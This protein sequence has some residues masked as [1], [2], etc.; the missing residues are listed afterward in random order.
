MAFAQ[1]FNV[2]TEFRFEIGSAVLGTKTLQNQVE[3][4]SGAVDGAIVNFQRL[5]MA[6]IVN[7]GTG[8]GGMIGLLMQG[9][10]A[11]EHYRKAQLNFTNAMTALGPRLTG[12]IE[13]FNKK[14][15]AS[16]AL[17]KTLA[18][19]AREFALPE[20]ELVGVAEALMPALGA[21]GLLGKNFD[22]L[23]EFSR[24]MLKAAPSM[25]LEAG[26]AMQQSLM[27]MTGGAR[28]QQT[29]FQR[30]TF[31]TEA[32]QQF[33]NDA[34]KFNKLDPHKKFELIL[35]SLKQFTKDARVL[36]ERTR[37]VSS[38]FM[39]IRNVL[40]G[41]NGILLPFGRMINDTFVVVLQKAEKLLHKYGREIVNN[42]TAFV[43]PMAQSIRDLIV[44]ALQLRDVAADVKK[45]GITLGIFG[46]LKIFGGI[47]I[48]ITLFKKFSGVFTKLFGPAIAFINKLGIFKFLL[49]SLRF[50]FTKL[51]WPIT[52]LIAAFQLISRAK[53]I[54]NLRDAKEL[55]RQMAQF[56]EQTLRL[57]KALAAVTMPFRYFF[58][59]LAKG[60]SYLFRWSY[61]IDGLLSVF[62]GFV[63]V[64]ERLA[65]G[66]V[67]VYSAVDALH[68]A[69]N[70]MISRFLD[71]NFQ[72]IGG[73][74]SKA[75]A[76][77]YE[78]S[79]KSFED[80]FGAEQTPVVQ[81]VNHFHGGIEI[82]NQF[83]EN[84]EPDR[85]AFTIKE[86]ILKAGTNRTQ[87]RNRTLAP[88]Y[89]TAGGL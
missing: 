67:M 78:R 59:E 87:A 3:K 47:S 71:F 25:G 68:F 5:G 45:A 65:A 35:R 61:I 81:Q 41:I 60:L 73:E 74:F 86:Q 77:S 20:A 39:R 62:E 66:I 82:R 54:A 46:I 53:A 38:Q 79:L 69:I 44:L 64:V 36:D 28:M 40:V 76:W 33:R 48:I 23:V 17:L 51:L 57:K 56:S 70:N 31:D 34:E 7:I 50:V 52:L 15:R 49:I 32:M 63:Q 6:A 1:I 83:K 88:V 9:S 8:G 58:D 10:R 18:E 19:K 12:P 75:F 37:L 84:L 11:W 89:G 22:K 24:N 43:E 29:F 13:T 26:L 55:P 80:Q 30:L 85:I 72:D 27:M 14:A 42:V 21:E 2:A 16:S 4:L